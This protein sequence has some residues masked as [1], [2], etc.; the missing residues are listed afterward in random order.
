MVQIVENQAS[1]PSPSQWSLVDHL[2]APSEVLDI[3]AGIQQHF[4]L[5]H[6]PQVEKMTCYTLDS[7]FPAYHTLVLRGSPLPDGQ[8]PSDATQIP[9]P[10]TAPFHFP[11]LPAPTW[12]INTQIVPPAKC[13]ASCTT[14]G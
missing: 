1:Q 11:I 7:S 6:L 13:S 12:R 4:D 8:E 10:P 9:A 5:S 2:D 3:Q 14:V